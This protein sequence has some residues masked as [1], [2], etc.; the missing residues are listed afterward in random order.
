[1]AVEYVER[2]PLDPRR[3]ARLPYCRRA[4]VDVDIRELSPAAYV[5]KGRSQGHP[6]PAA[7]DAPSRAIDDAGSDHDQREPLLP[8]HVPGGGL[9]NDLGERVRIP[10]V[11]LGLNGTRLVEYRPARQNCGGIDGQRTDQDEPADTLIDAGAQQPPHRHHR[12]HEQCRR[13]A[14]KGRS[15]VVDDIDALQRFAAGFRAHQVAAEDLDLRAVRRTDGLAQC[16]RRARRSQEAADGHLLGQQ[17]ANQVTAQEAGGP[18]DQ[19]LHR[20]TSTDSEPGQG[21][22]RSAAFGSGA[23]AVR[24]PSARAAAKIRSMMSVVRTISRAGIGGS[25]PV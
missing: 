9:L 3:E 7:Q 15:R 1:M 4:V 16:V 22:R 23:S 10:K 13:P 25:A 12:V 19:S 17:V 20:R 24:G 6:H 14:G 5:E 8:A 2:L 11:R 18:R 21:V